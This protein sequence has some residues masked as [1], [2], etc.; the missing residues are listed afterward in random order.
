[1]VVQGLELGILESQ[2]LKSLYI[3]TLCYLLCHDWSSLFFKKKKM[4]KNVKKMEALLVNGG[5]LASCSTHGNHL[6]GT[7]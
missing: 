2:A 6:V 7:Q 1:M 4:G 3:D 5:C